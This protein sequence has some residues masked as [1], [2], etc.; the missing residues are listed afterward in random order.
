MQTPV[1]KTFDGEWE[2]RNDVFKLWSCEGKA[3]VAYEKKGCL[4]SNAESKL[5]H[6]SIMNFIMANR[7]H[8]VLHRIRLDE[9]SQTCWKFKIHLACLVIYRMT[10]AGVPNTNGTKQYWYEV[11]GILLSITE[12]HTNNSGTTILPSATVPAPSPPVGVIY[13]P[14]CL[15]SLLRS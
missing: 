3:L 13:G 1:E 7:L 12:V 6:E 2:T 9:S 5:N 4:I 15:H 8:I 11:A 14:K 10:S